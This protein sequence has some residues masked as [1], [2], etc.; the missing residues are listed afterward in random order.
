MLIFRMKLIYILL[1]FVSLFACSPVP[2]IP[3]LSQDA[4]KKIPYQHRPLIEKLADDYRSVCEAILGR[5]FVKWGGEVFSPSDFVVN[6]NSLQI[7]KVAPRVTATVLYQNFSC[8]GKG[9]NPWSATSGIK[10]FVL[11]KREIFE[12]WVS[13][14]I[15]TVKERDGISLMLPQ[16]PVICGSYQHVEEECITSATWSSEEKKFIS[17]GGP[18]DLIKYSEPE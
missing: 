18:L 11:V 10:V 1:G 16:H 8:G 6:A 7:I 15:Y 17:T 3:N 14:E 12:G 9:S 13:G 4:L 2:V 5:D